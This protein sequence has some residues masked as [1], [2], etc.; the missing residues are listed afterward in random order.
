M[1]NKTMSLNFFSPKM[2]NMNIKQ[3]FVFFKSSGTK[4]YL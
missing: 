2:D 4:T 1:W 3:N